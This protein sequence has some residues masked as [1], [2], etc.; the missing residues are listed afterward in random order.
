[1][2]EREAVMDGTGQQRP[3]TR[4]RRLIAG[5][6]LA[7]LSVIT[8]IV[9]YNHGLEVVRL[10]GNTGLV[11]FLVPLVPDLMIISSSLTLLEAS[12]LKAGGP[13]MAIAALGPSLV[14]LGPDLMF[15]SP[16]RTLREASALKPGAPPMAMAALVA[17]IGWTVA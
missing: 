11:A 13:P 12:A 7:V 4:S 14:P 6:T 1:M 9:S 3:A 15:I 5:L 16:P 17:G 10:V 2:R 8:G